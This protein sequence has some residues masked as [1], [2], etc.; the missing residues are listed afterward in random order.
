MTSHRSPAFY[1]CRTWVARQE[2]NLTRGKELNFGLKV[3]S[4]FTLSVS[5]I[6]GA[7]RSS[8]FS[9]RLFDWSNMGSFV[10]QFIAKGS[11]SEG[12]KLPCGTNPILDSV[13]EY[14]RKR[15]RPRLRSPCRLWIS[16]G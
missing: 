1:A 7:Q 16:A 3:R 5:P 2:R 12:N 8:Q 4:S 13:L 9:C 15:S 14:Q 11:A 6:L 10:V